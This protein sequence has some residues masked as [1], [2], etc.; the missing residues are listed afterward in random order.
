M[1]IFDD[2]VNDDDALETGKLGLEELAPRIKELKTREDD[3]SKARL[4]IEAEM[5]TC[6]VQDVKLATVKTYVSD[7]RNILVESDSTDRKAFLRSFIKKIV[8][9][10]E[11]VVVTYKLPQRVPG[12]SNEIEK[13][14]PIDNVCGEGDSNHGGC[15]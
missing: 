10:G 8:V 13:V 2:V 6:D 1:R 11:R 7:L 15:R 9:D 4:Q 14:L 12:V 5:I 3:L